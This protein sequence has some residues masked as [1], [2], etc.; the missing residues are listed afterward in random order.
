MFYTPGNHKDHGL[1]HSPFKAIVSPRPIGWISTVSNDG[2]PNLGPY[3]FFNAISEL[4]PMVG[5][6]SSPGG[7]GEKDSLANARDTGCFVV[8]IVSKAQVD[9]MNASSADLPRG[10][11]EFEYAGLEA[12]PSMLVDAPRVKGAPAQLE[13]EL[14]DILEL[15]E[16][17]G[18][19]RNHWV[20]GRVVGIHIDDRFIV[21]GKLDVTL[22]QPV[23]RLGY[24]DY[25]VIE[26]MIQLER[27]SV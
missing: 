27:P 26:E 7:G 18:G 25:A 3:S 16:M 14:W 6:S 21:D 9:G 20:M 13:C 12:E 1:P 15:P 2:K 23:S 22:Y 11:S 4:P 10:D 17:A 8:N 19:K 5:F 24:K